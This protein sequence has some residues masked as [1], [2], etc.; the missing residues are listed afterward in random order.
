MLKILI[1]KI[2]LLLIIIKKQVIGQRVKSILNYYHQ[3]AMIIRSLMA[4]AVSA[5]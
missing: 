3:I 4:L 2:P 5:I 1:Q